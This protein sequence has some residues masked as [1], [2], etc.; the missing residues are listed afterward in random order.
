MKAVLVIHARI[1]IHTKCAPSFG[2]Y[3]YMYNMQTLIPRE[4]GTREL[5]AG[6]YD[7]NM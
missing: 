2:L 3:G 1:I 7:V 6:N 4:L 5:Q